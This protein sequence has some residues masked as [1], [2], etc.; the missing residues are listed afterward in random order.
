VARTKQKKVR[1]RRIEDVI[2]FALAHPIRIEIL[3][4]LNEAVY[5]PNELAQIIGKSLHTVNYHVSELADDGAIELARTENVGN[6]TRHY[7]HAVKQPYVSEK[8]ALEMTPQQRQVVA[9]V[10]LQCAMAEAMS[11]LR[12]GDMV[13]DPSNVFLSWRWFNVDREG[14][15]EMMK[16]LIESWR[17]IQEIEARSAARRAGSGEPAVTMIAT[18]LGFPRRREATGAPWTQEGNPS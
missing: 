2:S 14:Q 3:M 12:A 16:E 5:T 4:L 18:S 17:R 15:G 10:T 6:W 11:A 13:T 8:E 1:R 9:G 7:Y